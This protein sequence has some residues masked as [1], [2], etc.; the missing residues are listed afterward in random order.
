[1][2]SKPS[3][4]ES[5]GLLKTSDIS[6]DKNKTKTRLQINKIGKLG[7][8]HSTVFFVLAAYEVCGLNTRR[9]ENNSRAEIPKN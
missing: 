2:L 1:M 7:E 9:S 5:E 3:R 4:A 8:R 6:F